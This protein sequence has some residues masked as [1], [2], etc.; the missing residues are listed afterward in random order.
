MIDD[1]PDDIALT[2]D[3]LAMLQRILRDV[4]RR[5]PAYVK[6]LGEDAV[7]SLLIKLFQQGH[8]NEDE[9]RSLVSDNG[10]T[11]HSTWQPAFSSSAFAANPSRR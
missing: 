8:T 1:I 2:P 9:L 7:A 10:P 11:R 3:D 5:R 6:A 4:A